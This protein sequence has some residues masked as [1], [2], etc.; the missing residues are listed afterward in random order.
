[1]LCSSQK[2]NPQPDTVDPARISRDDAKLCKYLPNRLMVSCWYI[3]WCWVVFLRSIGKHTVS[4]FNIDKQFSLRWWI[5][6]GIDVLL[7]VLCK[8]I[9]ADLGEV[10]A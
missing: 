5:D 8:Q 10:I 2:H 6:E 7:C 4:H 3:F 1:M 9:D